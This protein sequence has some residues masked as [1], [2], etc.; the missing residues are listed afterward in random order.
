M[1]SAARMSAGSM[2]EP[3]WTSRSARRIWRLT[4]PLPSAALESSPWLKDRPDR[5]ALAISMRKSGSSSSKALRRADCRE[6]S[7]IEVMNQPRRPPASSPSS[8]LPRISPSSSAPPTTA[9]TR[10]TTHVATFIASPALS[11]LVSI[12]A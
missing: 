5:S 10:M 8:T 12:L 1:R 11:S 3:I 4:S 2:V 7:Q 6:L 9:T